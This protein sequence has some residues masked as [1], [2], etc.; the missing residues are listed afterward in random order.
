MDVERARHA[1]GYELFDHTAEVGLRAW[2]PSPAE[3][4]VAAARGL[5]SVIVDPATVHARQLRTLRVEAPDAPTLLVH[6]L[7]ELLFLLDADL[8]V[9]A[10]FSISQWT[11]TTMIA[12]VRGEEADP[13]R[14]GFRSTVKTVTFHQLEV[15]RTDDTCWIQ[16]ILD[17]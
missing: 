16:A 8:F 1:A 5:C 17:V 10:D 4:F 2:G 9:P 7:N 6:W 14:H 15:V 11:D 12:T 13:A 3:A